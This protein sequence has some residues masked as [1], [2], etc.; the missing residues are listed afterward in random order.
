MHIGCVSTTLS[1]CVYTTPYFYDITL[2][3]NICKISPGSLL[4]M[5]ALK[6]LT[7]DWFI[8]DN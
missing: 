4:R 1:V 3:T 8:F 7:V 5:K 6:F 2:W